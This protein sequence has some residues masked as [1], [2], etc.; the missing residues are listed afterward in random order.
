MNLIEEKLVSAIEKGISA[1]EK[2]GDFVLDNAPG[3]IKQFII[4]RY[5]RNIGVLLFSALCLYGMYL[6]LPFIYNESEGTFGAIIFAIIALVASVF[7]AIDAIFEL[8]KLIIAPKIYIIDY[9]I[10]STHPKS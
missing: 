4:W 2:T 7:F 8:M 10:Q 6:F 1:A 3:L 5:A 9:Y